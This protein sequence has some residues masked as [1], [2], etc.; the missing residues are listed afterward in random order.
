MLYES[1]EVAIRELKEV[2]RKNR[3]LTLHE[4][5]SVISILEQHEEEITIDEYQELEYE[6]D[7]LAQYAESL[8]CDIQL[9]Q[10]EID[11]LEGGI[12]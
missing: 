5:D 6:R 9:M 11:S 1:I 8:E 7:N 10:D 12:L 3:P 4:L 2:Y